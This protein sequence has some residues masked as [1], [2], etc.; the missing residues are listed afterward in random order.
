MSDLEFS[1]KTHTADN[2]ARVEVGTVTH[3][4]RAFEALGA[5]RDEV[6]GF[7]G[8]YVSERAPGLFSLTT[9]EGVEIAPLRKVHTWKQWAF[10]GVRVEIFAWSATIG[11]RTYTGRNSGPGMFVRMRSGKQV[12]P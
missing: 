5:V 11:G 4:G 8:A 3:E 1:C 6:N 7:V 9:W 10:G 2:G 12:A